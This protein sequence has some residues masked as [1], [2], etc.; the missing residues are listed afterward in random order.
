MYDFIHKLRANPQFLEVLG[1]GEQIRDYCYVSDMVDCFMMVAERGSGVYNAAG[2]Y[3]V[4]IKELA[5]LMVSV[6]S[7]EATIQYGGKTWAGDVNT[8]YADISRIRGL[9][10]EPKVGFEDGVRKMIAWF[11]EM[12]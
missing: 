3:P 8:L 12:G 10:F 6:I 7:P 2:G 4:S 5:N 9:G 11:E 1:T